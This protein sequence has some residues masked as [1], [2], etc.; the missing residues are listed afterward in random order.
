MNSAHIVIAQTVPTLILVYKF[1]RNIVDASYPI[2]Q[3]P[4]S[5]TKPSIHYY[6]VYVK[7]FSRLPTQHS[8]V[9]G[10]LEA[11]PS[12]IDIYQ[13]YIT[14]K[15]PRA[16]NSTDRSKSLLA[17]RNM[18]TLDLLKLTLRGGRLDTCHHRSKSHLFI[19]HGA[20][21]TS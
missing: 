14:C 21:N 4:T 17:L 2:R 3:I 7:C 19:S 11:P 10:H 1:S 20:G 13:K 5:Y 6:V 12:I 15:R 8:S 9:K 16:E 18:P